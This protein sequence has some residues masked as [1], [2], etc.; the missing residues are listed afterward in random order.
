MGKKHFMEEQIA[1]ALSR[2]C[3]SAGHLRTG[4]LSYRAQYRT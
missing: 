1:F 4:G 3:V 2:L